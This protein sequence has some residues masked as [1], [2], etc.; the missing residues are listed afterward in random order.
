MLGCVLAVA[1]CATITK[2]TTQTISINTPGA[3]GASCTLT[4]SGSNK[5]VIT[6]AV[7][8]VE[9]SQQ[10]IAVR[11]TKECF[12]DGAAVVASFTEGMTAGNI[13]LG[14]VIGLG[15]DAASGAMNHYADET[16]VVMTSIPGCR[17]KV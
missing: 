17:A 11:C 12:Q 16:L 13:L 3:A 5:V 14:G 7:L 8:T 2:G 6:P 10:S 1:G 15:V 9:K 4:A